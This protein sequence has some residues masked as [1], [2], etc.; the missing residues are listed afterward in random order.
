VLDERIFVAPEPSAVLLARAA[1]AVN[2][3]WWE[4]AADGNVAMVKELWAKEER[5]DLLS[6]PLKSR[7]ELNT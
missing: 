3:R 7:N 5:Q 6:V 4:R 1:N 2:R